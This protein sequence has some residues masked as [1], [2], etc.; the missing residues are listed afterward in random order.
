MSAAALTNWAVI[1]GQR[2]EYPITIVA[3]TD[4]DTKD[5]DLQLVYAAEGSRPRGPNPHPDVARNLTL[6]SSLLTAGPR[7]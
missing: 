7:P 6:T 4:V 3:V 5:E 2:T 1:T